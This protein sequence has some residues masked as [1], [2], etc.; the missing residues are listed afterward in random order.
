MVLSPRDW[1]AASVFVAAVLGTVYY[2][3]GAWERYAPGPDHRETCWAELQSDYWA[4]MRWCKYAR[5][6]YDILLLGD[7]VVWGQEVAHDE[8]ISHY[9]NEYLG[10]HVVANLGNDGLFMAGI[11][12]MVVHYGDY[13]SGTNIILQFNPLWLA[14]PKNDLRG[15]EKS[16]YHHPRL[17]PQFDP[18]I[19]YYHDLNTRIGYRVEHIFR[20]FPFVRHLMA[21]YFDNRSIA[22]WM[23]A[24]PYENVLGAITFEAAPVMAEKQGKGRSWRAKGM[25]QVNNPFVSLEESIQFELFLDAVEHLRRSGTHVFIMVGPYNDHYEEPESRRRL[26]ALVYEAMGIFD[27][28]RYPYYNTFELELPSE[29][30]G[31]DCHLLRKGNDL[32]ARGLVADEGFRKWLTASAGAAVQ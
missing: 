7:S 30:F 13:L 2:G 5:D 17:I 29:T 14:S 26:F 28:R 23:M 22:G 8:T 20:V 32:L 31:D 18:R 11:R 1:L 4:Y 6:H 25:E 16:R 24:H 3:W 12:G 21:N 9:I 15:E 10:R 19:T 27:E